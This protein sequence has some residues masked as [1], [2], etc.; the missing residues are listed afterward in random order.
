MYL[1]IN[2]VVWLILPI[3]FFTSCLYHSRKVECHGN[4]DDFNAARIGGDFRARPLKD[5]NIPKTRMG[6]KTN[7]DYFNLGIKKFDN[8]TVSYKM[9][10]T[11][12]TLFN[13]NETEIY[14][15]MLKTENK[16]S[17]FVLKFKSSLVKHIKFIGEGSD[18]NFYFTVE[19]ESS[20]NKVY[21]T[22]NYAMF[23]SEY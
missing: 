14:S 10:E 17:L 5:K 8:K 23:F 18:G 20:C 1:K 4:A 19:Q 21:I 11:L 6:E 3:Y 7:K 2:V 15:L 13:N 16:D 12:I 22:P 9:G